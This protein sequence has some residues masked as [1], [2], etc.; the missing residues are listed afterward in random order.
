MTAEGS[1]PAQGPILGP[2]AQGSGPCQLHYVNG[3][4]RVAGASESVSKI[5][6]AAGRDVGTLPSPQPG[7]AGATRR[8]RAGIVTAP[9]TWLPCPVCP[10][11]PGPIPHPWALPPKP[12]YLPPLSLA[13]VRFLEEPL[14]LQEVE[15]KCALGAGSMLWGPCRNWQRKGRA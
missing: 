5:E 11:H 15:P 6:K 10:H 8:T 9:D 12:P 13:C 4:V 1:G 7:S 3:C 2:S 14:C